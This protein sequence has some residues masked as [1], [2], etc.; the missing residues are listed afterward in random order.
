MKIK[1]KKKSNFI[2]FAT[3]GMFLWCNFFF[4]KGKKQKCRSLKNLRIKY[5]T[6]V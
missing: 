5:D 3:S 6:L 4:F 1:F 2:I